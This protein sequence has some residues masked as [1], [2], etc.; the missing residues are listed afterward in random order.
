MGFHSFP[1]EIAGRDFHSFPQEIGRM[2]IVSVSNSRYAGGAYFDWTGR[3]ERRRIS[4]A[5]EVKSRWKRMPTP[6][7]VSDL[8]L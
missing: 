6:W 4:S 1:Q 3:G 2:W 5:G 8:K 7:R